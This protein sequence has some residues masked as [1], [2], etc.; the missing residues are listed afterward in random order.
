PTKTHRNDSAFDLHLAEPLTIRPGETRTVGLGIRM[1]IPD[2]MWILLKE[3]SSAAKMGISLRG[4]VI[5]QDYTGEIK[6]VL[7]N[8]AEATIT[9]DQNARVV[10]AIPMTRPEAEIERIGE[11]Q[12]PTTDRQNRGFGSTG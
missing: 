1:V 6:A 2:G 11:D 10:Q 12:I 4:G 9:Y 8:S 3:R 7:H 5:D